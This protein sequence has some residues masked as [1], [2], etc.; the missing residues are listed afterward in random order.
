M[1]KGI[2]YEWTNLVNNKKYIGSHKGSA[3]DGYTASGKLIK[4][5]F[6]KYGMDNFIRRVL[7]FGKDYKELEEFCLEEVDAANSE[8]YYN[9]SNKALGWNEYARKKG[10]KK[11]KELRN[12]NPELFIHSDETKQKMSI[13]KKG[14]PFVGKQFIGHGKNNGRYGTGHLFVEI[15]TGFQGYQYDMKNKFGNKCNTTI[16]LYSNKIGKPFTYGAHKGLQF[17]LKENK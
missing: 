11:I 10:R 12:T 2:V 5:A 13:A 3:D 4:Y 6:D 8:N 9:I 7:Y 15:T 17:K 16:M 14:K 1:D